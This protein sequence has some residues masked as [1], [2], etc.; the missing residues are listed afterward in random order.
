MYKINQ[1]A[2]NKFSNDLSSWKGRVKREM[3][4][5]DSSYATISAQW[6]MITEDNYETFKTT[7][8]APETKAK[9]KKFKGLQSRNVG[10][11]RLGSRGYEGKRHVWAKEDA[12]RESHGIP[13]PLAEF[14]DPQERDFIRA[15]YKW[16][17]EKK[18]WYTD[19]ITRKLI[20]L[21]VIILLPPYI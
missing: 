11:H 19:P 20:R 10:V 4:K 1:K 12:E 3:A 15:R 21:L 14:T 13:D 5:K 7:C 16:D 2:L 17:K 9:S 6:P 18:V 8:A